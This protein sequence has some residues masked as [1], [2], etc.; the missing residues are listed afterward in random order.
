M[1]YILFTILFI[2]CVEI[3]DFLSEASTSERKNLYYR[4]QVDGKIY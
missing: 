1:N 4:F 3:F 2:F